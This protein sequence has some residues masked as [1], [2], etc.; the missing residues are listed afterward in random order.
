MVSREPV[1]L[2]QPMLDFSQGCTFKRKFCFRLSV[3]DLRDDRLSA[4]GVRE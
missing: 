3:Q 2:V 4:E 1:C